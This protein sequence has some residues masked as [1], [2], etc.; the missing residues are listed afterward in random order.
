MNSAEPRPV[1]QSTGDQDLYV[2]GYYGFLMYEVRLSARIV[3][4]KNPGRRMGRL[5]PTRVLEV[6]VAPPETPRNAQQ[7][8][9]KGRSQVD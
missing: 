9:A 1:G 4:K 8:K 7:C 3:H 5:E 6:M 2:G